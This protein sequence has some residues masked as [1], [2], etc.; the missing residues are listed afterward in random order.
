VQH[1]GCAEGEGARFLDPRTFVDQ[2]DDLPVL[3]L[4]RHPLFEVSEARRIRQAGVNERVEIR[5]LIRHALE[6]ASTDIECAAE[7]AIATCDV[8]LDVGE[9]GQFVDWS[10]VW[11][12]PMTSGAGSRFG[13]K[14]N[15]S[16][17]GCP[18]RVTLTA[19]RG[20]RIA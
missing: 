3:R 1:G 12:L 14:F 19:F 13:H 5:I 11:C 7:L 2:E 9:G 8:G 17:A 15:V 4:P 20:T 6:G 18:L 16:Y 10:G